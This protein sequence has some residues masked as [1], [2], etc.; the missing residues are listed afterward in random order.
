M[1]CDPNTTPRHDR[2]E[3][4]SD[5]LFLVCRWC[6][7]DTLGATSGPVP[8][9]GGFSPVIS[10]A[11]TLSLRESTCAEALWKMPHKGGSI[12]AITRRVCA[13]LCDRALAA[14]FNQAAI[15][16]SFFPVHP[17]SNDRVNIQTASSTCKSRAVSSG[18]PESRRR[19]TIGTLFRRSTRICE[20]IRQL[21]RAIKTGSSTG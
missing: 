21:V 8:T 14:V 4:H 18:P 10:A 9:P 12:F 13:P 11:K 15:N 19:T 1:K 5:W 16:S 20:R 17:A 2:R 6:E 3:Y 7:E